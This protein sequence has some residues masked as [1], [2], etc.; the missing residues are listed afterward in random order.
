MESNQTFESVLGTN[1]QYKDR[2][3]R[4]LDSPY[5]A[6]TAMKPFYF[7]DGSLYTGEISVYWDA[8]LWAKTRALR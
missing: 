5:E 8:P 1:L 6:K 7:Y 3:S 4:N 2:L